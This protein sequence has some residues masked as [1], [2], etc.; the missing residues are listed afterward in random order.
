MLCITATYTKYKLSNGPAKKQYLFLKCFQS[1]LILNCT[2]FIWVICSLTF[3]NN[4]RGT[5]RITWANGMHFHRKTFKKWIKCTNAPTSMRWNRSHRSM[6]IITLTI[7]LMMSTLLQQP[8]RH[9]LH[10]HQ[11]RI[12]HFWIYL[13]VWSVKLWIRASEM[14]VKPLNRWIHSNNWQ[15][16][17]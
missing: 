5:V 9:L 11:D 12:D 6:H 14:H 17:I 13:A 8:N 10:Q 2:K 3:A 16:V 4:Y 15:H 7:W 1:F